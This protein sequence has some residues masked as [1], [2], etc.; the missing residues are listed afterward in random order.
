VKEFDL[1]PNTIVPV[2]KGNIDFKPAFENAKLAGMKYYF[3]EQ[4]TAQSYDDV[5]TSY[6]N[7]KELSAGHVHV[8]FIRHYGLHA[9]N[10][11]GD[12]GIDSFDFIFL[13][14]S[15]SLSPV[16]STGGT[17]IEFF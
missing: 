7:I 1:A 11:N 13:P 2:G 3:Y 4:D 15:H 5:V 16:F 14:F 10:I 17:K 8:H 6:N 9:R 12:F